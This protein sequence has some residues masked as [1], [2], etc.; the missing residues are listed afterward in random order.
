MADSLLAFEPILKQ[1]AWGGDSLAEFGKRV[2]DGVRIGESWELADLPGEGADCSVVSEGPESGRSLRALIEEDAESILG[3]AVP[4]PDGGFPLLIKLLDAREN[5]SVQLHPSARYAAEHPHTHLKTE[6]WVVLA[7]TPG[8]KAYVGLDP[9]VDLERFNTAM[10]TGR[11]LDILV[12][13][14]LQPGDCVFLESGLCHALG[15]GTVVAEVQMPSDTTFRVWDWDR[16]DPDRPLHLEEARASI[17]LGDE[18]RTDWPVMTRHSEARLLSSG[19]LSTRRLVDC[20]RFRIDQLEPT[21][22]EA[23]TCRF[24]F[25]SNGMPHVFMCTSGEG[26][27]EYQG[28]VLR[29]YPGRTILMPAALSE[30][31]FT[32]QVRDKAGASMLHAM[33]ADPMDTVRAD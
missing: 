6:A 30:V 9:S 28:E 13:R 21:P 32:L 12:E 7:A 3:R 18:Q 29:F 33:P 25:P 11:F 1:R 22:G 5:L 4:G 15:A 14:A 20:D 23:G 8:S 19:G 17:R 27:V 16:D 2:P 26:S 10:E 24:S 31:R